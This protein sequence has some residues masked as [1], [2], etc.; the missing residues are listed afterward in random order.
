MIQQAV[1][2]DLLRY[3]KTLL[4]WT[5]KIRT[6]EDLWNS[7]QQNKEADLEQDSEIRDQLAQIKTS[8]V[9]IL[10]EHRNGVS[11]AQ[12][13]QYLKRKL[14]FDLNLQRLGYPK[15]KDLILSMND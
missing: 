15:L 4:V 10:S 13:P 1:Q 3:H 7:N 12:L 11:L 6:K 5:D 9:D 14:K 8:L 2:D